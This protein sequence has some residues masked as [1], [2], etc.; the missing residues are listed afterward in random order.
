MSDATN[1][2]G[3]SS[4]PGGRGMSD[5]GPPRR[6][7]GGAARQ[8]PPRARDRDGL[9]RR[10]DRRPR[11]PHP[12]QLRL[13][14]RSAT[15]SSTPSVFTDSFPD[16][17]KAFWLDVR[18][19]CIVEVV[20]LMLG[21]MVALVA[22]D[23]RPGAVPAA[24]ARRSS[25]PT[26]SAASR[27]AARLPGR[28]RDPGARPQRPADRAGRAGRDRAGAVL[29]RLRQR[30]LPRRAALRPPR[31]AR[32]RRWRSGSPSARRCAT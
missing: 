12:D 14:G 23:R 5:G 2:P 31:P 30:G 13:A 28:L 1:G 9:D 3:R 27:R 29:R 26:S 10:R 22:D 21:L 18:V 24:A 32:R 4:R 20:V 11:G 8:G 16:I 19:F 15:R 25:T 7:G 17:L 6:A